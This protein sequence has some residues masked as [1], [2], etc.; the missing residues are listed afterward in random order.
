MNASDVVDADNLVL[1]AP[2]KGATSFAMKVQNELKIA[3]TPLLVMEKERRGEREINIRVS[4]SSPVALKAVKNKDVAVVDDMVR[5]GNTIVE[6]CELL[7]SANPRRV[8]I[9]ITHFFYTMYNVYMIF[10]IKFS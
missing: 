7:Q 6:C 1:C 9:F 2:D 3:E 4:E 10:T 5:T 8:V